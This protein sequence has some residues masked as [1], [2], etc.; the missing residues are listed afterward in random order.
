[1][2][3][4]NLSLQ[5]YREIAFLFT[6]S[7]RQRQNSGSHC[8]PQVLQGR[9]PLVSVK[10]Q[11]IFSI[12]NSILDGS[13]RGSVVLLNAIPFLLCNQIPP[14]NYLTANLACTVLFLNVVVCGGQRYLLLPFYI[15]GLPL[16][17][18]TEMFKILDPLPPARKITQPPL[19]TFST[20]SA[21]EHIPLP[22]S[23]RTRTYLMEAHLK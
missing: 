9:C 10:I 23:A 14:C 1:M 2:R 19:L 20:M 22:P 6:N 18:H 3:G 8:S 7:S 15:R 12:R 17:T 13:L 4:H 11:V 21:F 5:V 16:S